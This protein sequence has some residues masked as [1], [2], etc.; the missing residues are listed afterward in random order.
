MFVSALI[1]GLN[2]EVDCRLSADEVVS[3]LEKHYKKFMFGS[4]TKAKTLSD[5]EV[6]PLAKGAY[7]F[8]VPIRHDDNVFYYSGK[9]LSARIGTSRITFHVNSSPQWQIIL[10]CV[11]ILSI[12]LIVQGLAPLAL[13]L[14]L[15]AIMRMY[16]I[17]RA[18]HRADMVFLQIL[19]CK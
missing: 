4:L 14:M 15:F 17:F 11:L 7:E 18:L 1:S 16:L 2:F 12:V 3:R 5:F 9:I 8:R 13:V 19:N 6:T 10:G